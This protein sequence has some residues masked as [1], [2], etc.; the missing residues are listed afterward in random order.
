MAYEDASSGN[1]LTNLIP[2]MQLALD[3][4]SRELVGMIP[5]VTHDASVARA[6]IGQT[7]YSFVAP[8]A[9][10][11]NVAA[12]PVPPDDGEQT[13]GNI[14]LGI[15]KS[16]YIPIRWQGEESMQINNPGG[17]GVS[18][19]LKDQFAQGMRTL[20][21]EI[22]SDLAGLYIYGSRGAVPNDTTLFKTNLADAANVRKILAD[23]GAPLSDLQLVVDTS[24]GAA[25]RTL[26]QLSKVNEGGDSSL[27][28]QGVLLDIYGMAIRES[29]QIKTPAVGTE[30]SGTLGTEDYAVGA[31]TVALA[32]AGTG[33]VL[34]GDLMT[35]AN[36]GDTTTQYVV[37]TGD[38]DISGGG[39]IVIAAPGL[40]KA[41][42]ANNCAI[43]VYKSSARNLA[44][45]KSAIVLATR[46]PALPEGGD[47]AVDRTTITDPRS[48]LSF[49]VSMYKQYRQVRIELAIAWGVKVVKPEHVAI[50]AA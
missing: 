16:R 9:T 1:T 7:I 23:N 48:G 10:A 42:T 50:L 5:A 18:A 36:T 8:A 13:I 44:F 20:C 17:P 24:T 31:T 46:Q 34:A 28:R 22:E 6:A 15:T 49:E 25:L 19:I 32:S 47:M 38:A 11:G 43:A 27:L 39:N 14:S 35:I 40:L 3:T 45:S 12:A 21:N 26:T 30:D 33:T 37:L 41:I 2:T 29:A 4:V